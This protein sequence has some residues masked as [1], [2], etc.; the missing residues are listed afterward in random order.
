MEYVRNVRG[1]GYIF[2]AGVQEPNEH[3]ALTTRSEQID[4]VRVTIEE[5]EERTRPVCA[6]SAST[7]VAGDAPN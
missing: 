5:H 3:Q 4:V 6:E 7:D 2:E 1:R